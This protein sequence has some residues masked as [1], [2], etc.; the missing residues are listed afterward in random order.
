MKNKNLLYISAIILISVIAYG[1]IKQ[2][3]TPGKYDDLAKC[4][5]S[6]GIIMYG[7]DWCSHC[8]DQKALFGKSFKHIDYR[9]CDFNK[10]ECNSAGVKGYPTWVI[11]NKE[12]SGTRSL[13]QLSALSNC[14]F[15]KGI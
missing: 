9:N 5:T 11:N 14:E 12:Y 15:G 1:V 7:T 13:E 6:K 8:Q 4:L 3:K 10:E 2:A